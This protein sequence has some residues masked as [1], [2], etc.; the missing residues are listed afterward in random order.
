MSRRSCRTAVWDDHRDAVADLMIDTVDG[1]AP[2]FKALGARPADLS[3][4]DL[5]RIFGLVGGD[6]FHGA[7]DLDQMFSARPL[8][9]HADYRGPIRRAL[10]VRLRH[11]SRRRRHRDCRGTM[12]RGKSCG[13]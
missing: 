3:P 2:N 5:E 12:R 7:L 4:L 13:I 1:H 6:I 8:L 11:A 10:H 9:G